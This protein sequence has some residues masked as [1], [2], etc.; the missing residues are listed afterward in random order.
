MTGTTD[1]DELVRQCKKNRRDAQSTLYKQLSPR[2][3]GVCL[4]YAANRSEAEDILQDSFVKIFTKIRQFDFKGSFE[5]WARRVVV[6]C[7]LSYFRRESRLYAVDSTRN[8]RPT[9]C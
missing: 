1:F 4:R 6:N 8:F 5:G 7:A 2:L 3:F 9:M